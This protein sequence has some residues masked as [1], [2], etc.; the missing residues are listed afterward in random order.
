[1]QKNSTNPTSPTVIRQINFIPSHKYRKIHP[2]LSEVYQSLSNVVNNVM[3]HYRVCNKVQNRVSE[4]Y[5]KHTQKLFVIVDH[6]TGSSR[7]VTI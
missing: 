1:M 6:L 5:N 7:Y 2:K 3:H 4:S